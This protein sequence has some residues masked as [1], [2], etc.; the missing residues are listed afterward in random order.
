MSRTHEMSN[1]R[2]YRLWKS[3][4]SRCNNAN[5]KN[6]KDYGGRGIKICSEWN[7]FINFYHW[8]I[9]NGY[10]D[11]L[12]IER[13]DV[14]KGYSPDNCKWIPRSEQNFN[15][16]NSVKY[17]YKGELLPPRKISDITGISVYTIYDAAKRG[18]TDFTNYI[19]R[20]SKNKNIYARKNKYEIWINGKYMGCYKTLEE[21]ILKRDSLLSA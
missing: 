12:T 9:N 20:H 16:Q 2:I 1:T 4:R 18:I 14:N 11:N 3:M 5:R 15:K 21:A 8:S 17:M 19:P 6:Y 7:D 10:N 13:I